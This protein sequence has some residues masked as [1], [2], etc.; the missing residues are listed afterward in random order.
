MKTIEL[1]NGVQVPQLGLGVWQSGNGEALQGALTAA[2]NTGYRHIDTA[3]F[4]HNEAGVGQAIHYSGIDR[5]ELF[6]TTKVWNEDQGYAS[7]LKA[8]ERSLTLLNTPYI[9]LYLVH[10][11]VKGKERDTWSAMEE[12][13]RQGKVKAI[14]V[15]NFLQHHLEALLSYCT[16]KP[17]INQLEHHPYLVQKQLQ[18]FCQQHDIRFE[19]WSPLMQGGVFAIPLLQDLSAKYHKTIA[20]IVLRWNLQNDIISIPKSIRPERI[21]ENFNIWDFELSPEDL[22][23][24][25][26]LDKGRRVGPDPD[27]FG[28]Y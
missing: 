5:S 25:D 12:L 3:S 24:I 1:Y 16:I 18:E 9:D 10:W 23:L 19:A 15:S 28:N 2:F 21:A 6:I 11:P 14:G 4:Y 13:Y 26:T 27:V 8:C 22:A 7:T 17:M 20:Q